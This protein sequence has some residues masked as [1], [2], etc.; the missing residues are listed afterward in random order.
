[1]VAEG[2]LPP[3]RLEIRVLGPVEIAW[4]GLPIDV[5]GV[6]ARALVARL[7]ID[8][9]MIVSVDRLVDSLW[10]DNEGAGAEIAMRSTISRLR[11]RIRDAGA[12]EDVIVTRAPG[13]LLDLPAEATDVFR[14]ERLVAEGRVQLARRRPSDCVRLLSEAEGLWR[15]PA[16][17]EV[18]DEPF[19]RAEARRLEELRLLATET[20]M[21]AELT[22]GQHEAVTGELEA[23]TSANPMR[24]RLWSQRILALYRCGRQAEAL[25]VFQDLRAV[26]VDELGIEPG[27]DVSWLEHAVLAQDPALDFPAPPEPDAGPATKPSTA[28]SSSKY[29]VRV[30][31]AQREGPLVGRGR[32]SGLLR[33]WWTS[34]G[35]GAG[36][37]LLIDGD[38]G[39]GKTWRTPSRRTARWC[40][41]AAA[42]RIRWRRSSPSRRRWGV[43]SSLSRRTAFRACRT[44]S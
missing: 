29:Q 32:E 15:G 13:Y 41:G 20:R 10:R 1:M 6:K 36:R 42:T 27:H 16:F 5:G 18:R 19:A 37:L 33:D 34:V 11:K 39:I 26:L 44:G 28:S 38:P 40:C 17:S 24:E 9:H 21:D 23:L 8:R 30:P 14:L 2:E 35:H 22:M 3:Q 4:D 31:A 12:P 25:R 7:L 43:T